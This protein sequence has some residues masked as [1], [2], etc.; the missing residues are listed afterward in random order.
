MRSPLL[1]Q[2]HKVERLESMTILGGE[3]RQIGI[4]HSL[5]REQKDAPSQGSHTNDVSTL[6]VFEDYEPALLDIE[7][8][9]HLIVL[10]WQDKA[11]RSVLQTHTPWG[12][13]IHGVFAT[14]SPNRP[15]PVGLCVVELME[16]N[17]RFLKVRG[18]DA[19]DGSPLID[20]K[21]YSSQVDLVHSTCIG[22]HKKRDLKP[23][24]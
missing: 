11:N 17:G 19:L 1:Y 5:Y 2:K 14:R 8:C 4:V 15:N 10:Y 3:L 23:Q 21:P 13:E 22:S 7:H 24:K 12:P 16:Q 6:E 18:M 9:S 20:I